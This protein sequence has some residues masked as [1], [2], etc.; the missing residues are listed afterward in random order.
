M[1]KAKTPNGIDVNIPENMDEDPSTH[2]LTS[3]TQEIKDYYDDYGYAVIKGVIEPE[4]CDELRECWNKEIKNF[5]GTIYRQ[6]T[7]KAEKNIFNDKGWVMNPILNIQSINRDLFPSFSTVGTKKVIANNKFSKVIS[8]L[9]DDDPKI[10]QSMYFEGN[11]AT[12]EHQDTYYLDSEHIG[13]MIGSWIA[14]EDIAPL[15]GR[16]F[17]VPKSH[18]IQ[19][20]EHN[21]KNNVATKHDDYI[22]TVINHYKESNC[23]V[24]APAL[25]KGDLLIW[26]SKTIHGSLDTQDNNSSRSSV[27]IH[28]IPNK[29]NFL[30]QQTRVINTKTDQ[31][32]NVHFYRPKD[33]ASYI[34]KFIKYIES[35]IPTPFYLLK[36]LLI[37]AMMRFKSLKSS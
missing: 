10:V 34:N 37:L 13:S 22:Q 25:S 26:H 24:R 16:F 18:K 4:I 32:G 7:C 23:E 33:Q 6:T 28:A 20:D 3:E 19:I 12:W 21:I 1:L 27:T 17:I 35:T 30:Q 5:N 8:S 15:A 2:F 11:S 9:L 29:H 14:I 31:I 36:K